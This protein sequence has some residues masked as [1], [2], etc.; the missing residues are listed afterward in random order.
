MCLVLR[1]SFRS[2]VATFHLKK[3]MSSF[4][5]RVTL[6]NEH[7]YP[8]GRA[9]VLRHLAGDAADFQS[10]TFATVPARGIQECP[11]S[12]L[13]FN[14]H[15]LYGLVECAPLLSCY[16]FHSLA[17]MQVIHG[18]GNMVIHLYGLT[19]TCLPILTVRN[20]WRASVS[21]SVE[22]LGATTAAPN[23]ITTQSIH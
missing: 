13:G 8:Q 5:T 7:V 4:T 16:D 1:Q 9:V 15:H 17:H 18:Y 22:P 14:D 11:I 19:H 2:A 21:G 20:V 12:S 23:P 10:V 3:S 6:F